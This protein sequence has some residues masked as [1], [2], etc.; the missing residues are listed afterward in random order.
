[1]VDM[2]AEFSTFSLFIHTVGLDND[3]VLE[4]IDWI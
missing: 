2:P 1:M 4:R 3:S